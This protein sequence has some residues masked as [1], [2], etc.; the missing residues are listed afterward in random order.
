MPPIRISDASASTYALTAHSRLPGETPSP[1]W[2]AGSATFT[3]VLSSRIM[4]CPM[5]MAM[6]V[7]RC[8]RGLSP[9]A[10]FYSARMARA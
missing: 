2:I 10:V 9:T 4:P 8:L 1:V 7:S 3:I 5:H 6:S